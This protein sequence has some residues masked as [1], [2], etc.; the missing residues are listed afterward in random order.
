[1]VGALLCEF[2]RRSAGSVAPSRIPPALIPAPP[3][4][5]APRYPPKELNL[6]VDA[7]QQLTVERVEVV[8]RALH[9]LLRDELKLSVLSAK[10][11]DS[12]P[13]RLGL[14]GQTVPGAHDVIN[15]RVV[16]ER[17]GYDAR[18]LLVGFQPKLAQRLERDVVEQSHKVAVFVEIFRQR[19]VCSSLRLMRDASRLLAQWDGAYVELLY[20]VDAADGEIRLGRE[21]EGV[22]EGVAV[23]GTRVEHLPQVDVGVDELPVVA[24]NH[25]R[26]VASGEDVR[27]A[28][29]PERAQGDGLRAQAQ[30]LAVPQRAGLGVDAEGVKRPI[31][32]AGEQVGHPLEG[33]EQHRAGNDAAPA[34]A[35]RRRRHEPQIR[36]G[37]EEDLRGPRA[38]RAQPCGGVAGVR[39]GGT[40]QARN[41]LTVE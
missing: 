36:H 38:H 8:H 9:L 20:V 23:E 27:R 37:Q 40:V 1:M 6:A 4:P 39:E 13:R 19:R 5:A 32:E 33:A 7:R 3:N 28:L 12:T 10:H 21:R 16:G 18:V 24:V 2:V 11:Q 25:R 35:Q 30:G 17:A 15:P 31:A 26:A 34:A 41:L 29:A 22:R 14:L